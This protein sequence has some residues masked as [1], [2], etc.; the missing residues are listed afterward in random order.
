MWTSGLSRLHHELDASYQL[1]AEKGFEGLRTRDV[2]SRVAINIATLHYYFPTK[3][4]LI[5]GVVQY[6]MQEMKTSRAPTR[7]AP[8]AL[9]MLRAEFEDIKIRLRDVPEQLV[10]LTELSVRAWRDPQIARILTY[11]DKGWHGNLYPFLPRASKKVYSDP[12]SIVP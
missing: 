7:S 10:V 9:E 2:A 1:I 3:E 4:A 11:L 12:I 6:L 8:S 5:Q